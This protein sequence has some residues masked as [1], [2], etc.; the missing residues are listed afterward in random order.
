MKTKSLLYVLLAFVLLLSCAC[1][2]EAENKTA[3]GGG[4][5]ADAVGDDA[6]TDTSTVN[7]DT[8]RN[9]VP[10]ADGVI[11]GGAEEGLISE[12]YWTTIAGSD[13]DDVIAGDFEYG[14]ATI[15]GSVSL[16]PEAVPGLLTA[17]EI[18]DNACFADWRDI[19][20]GETADTWLLMTKRRVCVTVEDAEGGVF[21]A[22]AYL[23]DRDGNK[24]FSALTDKKGVAYLFYGLDDEQCAE[25]ASVAVEYGGDTLTQSYS[26]GP[27]GYSFVIDGNSK[28]AQGKTKL[29]LMFVVDTTGSMSDELTYLQTEIEYVIGQVTSE[30]DC[31]LRTSVNFYRDE[32]DEYV[33]KYFAFETD[34][35]KVKE[36][37]SAQYATGGGD[38]P[39]AV[40]TA[41]KNAVYEH[42]WDSDSVKVMFLVLDA[43]P[44][45][46]EDIIAQLNETVKDAAEMGI[47]I[48]PV[49]SSGIDNETE[50]IL[51]SMAVL[52]GGT[53]TFLTDT[54]GVGGEHLKPTAKDYSEEKLN[55]LMV[56]LICEYCGVE[57]SPVY[58]SETTTDEPN[59]E[60]ADGQ[61]IAVT[62]ELPYEGGYD[63]DDVVYTDMGMDWFAYDTVD[64]A[65]DN[66]DAVFFAEVIGIDFR[67]IDIGVY[68]P[69]FMYHTVYTLHITERWTGSVPQSGDI[70]LPVLGGIDGEYVEKQ[71]EVLA[72]QGETLIPIVVGMPTLTEGETYMFALNKLENGSWTIIN[73]EQSI[74]PVL[75]GY[76]YM[77]ARYGTDE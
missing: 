77:E 35:E 60:P 23:L 2:S 40:H 26:A 43:P 9:T 47:R 1:T 4:T 3:Y 50:Y 15:A 11:G 65:I 73:P 63:I 29:D 17:A 25:P 51:R 12:T 53:Y 48:I 19:D 33:V 52:T 74:Y 28:A 6:S 42:A 36:N 21:G 16:Q 8:L 24:I 64:D 13:A 62:P 20:W 58:I 66:A 56:R 44:H 39:E 76:Q 18:R 32:G 31:E 59:E 45:C 72:A 37:I 68:E 41:L 70:E 57:I 7:S 69:A 38:Y 67:M 54:S 34:T 55:D 46:D 14:E 61:A 27:E 30:A 49:A 10:N 22:S 71:L 75:W 5:S